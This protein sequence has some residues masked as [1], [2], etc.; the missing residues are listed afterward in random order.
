M[1]VIVTVIC[2]ESLAARRSTSIAD[3]VHLL[4]LLFLFSEKKSVEDEKEF[5]LWLAYQIGEEFHVHH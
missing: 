4:F 1:L 2:L 5:S 3:F